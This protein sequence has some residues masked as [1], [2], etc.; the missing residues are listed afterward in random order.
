MQRWN[1]QVAIKHAEF[2]R[3]ILYFKRHGD[4]WTSLGDQADEIFAR[5]E[6]EE[7][8]RSARRIA[9]GRVV[10]ARR[11]AAIN[12]DLMLRVERAFKRSGLPKLVNISVDKR[13]WQQVLKWRT[14]E[15]TEHFAPFYL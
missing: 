1:E 14:E 15:L 5:L 11:T 8:T 6:D 2:H 4:A 10:C 7:T 13:L 3:A 12:K 9:S